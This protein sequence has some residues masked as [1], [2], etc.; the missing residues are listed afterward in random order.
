[1][2]GGV[3]RILTLNGT[4]KLL[5]GNI[6]VTVP[7]NLPLLGTDNLTLSGSWS[8]PPVQY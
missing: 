8:T 6:T 1:M 5:I 3:Y 2:K 4:V 7:V